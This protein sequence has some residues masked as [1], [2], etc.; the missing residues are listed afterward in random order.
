[1]PRLLRQA[2]FYAGAL[3]VVAVPMVGCALSLKLS[4]AECTVVRANDRISMSSIVRFTDFNTAF[5]VS[6][7]LALVALLDA[8]LDYEPARSARWLCAASCVSLL[9]PFVVP[10][11][12]A[13]SYTS[14]TGGNSATDWGHLA[15]AGGGTFGLWLYVMILMFRESNVATMSLF[16]T[17][18]A[19]L[20]IVA[21]SVLMDGLGAIGET[22]QLVLYGVLWGEF[23]IAGA[24]LGLFNYATRD[25]GRGQLKMFNL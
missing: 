22:R 19:S 11:S 25:R 4:L 12:N 3:G 7:T 23:G 8:L 10:I 5:S 6:G 18:T 20:A 16:C 17:F 13:E 21:S 15:G 1:M 14:S 2:A 9:A 24:I